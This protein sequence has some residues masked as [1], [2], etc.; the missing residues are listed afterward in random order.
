MLF[1]VPL[2]SEE[3]C[4]SFYFFNLFSFF[5]S[6]HQIHFVCTLFFISPKFISLINEKKLFLQLYPRSLCPCPGSFFQYRITVNIVKVLALSCVW[7]FA[8]PWT[9]S[10]PG[11]S[12]PGILQARIMESVA[13]P[14]SRGSSRSR[15]WIRISH[16]QFL[17]VCREPLYYQKAW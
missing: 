3:R 15:N 14:F 9:C 2:V 16:G 6:V 12:V 13:V 8:T 4:L 17:C 11:S 7:L 5:L 10:P 1:F